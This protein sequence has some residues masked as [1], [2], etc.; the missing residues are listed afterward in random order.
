MKNYKW[1]KTN[2]GWNGGREKL[3]VA[4]WGAGENII[5]E[6][7]ALGTCIFSLSVA[8]FIICFRNLY[9]INNLNAISRYKSSEVQPTE[10]HRRQNTQSGSLNSLSR[11]I[12]DSLGLDDSM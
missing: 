11:Y 8:K 5:V 4:Q 1:K 3:K 9:N 10:R 2:L 12:S 6:N 7:I